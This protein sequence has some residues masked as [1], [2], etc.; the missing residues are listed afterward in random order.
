ME[1]MEWLIAFYVSGLLA[2]FLVSS[3]MSRKTYYGGEGR[4]EEND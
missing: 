3:R 2:V 4:G 1:L